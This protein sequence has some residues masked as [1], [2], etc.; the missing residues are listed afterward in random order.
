MRWANGAA[1]RTAVRD[2]LMVVM[3]LLLCASCAHGGDDV[4]ASAAAAS[5]SS[6]SSSAAAAASSPAR[7]SVF[8]LEH[9]VGGKFSQRGKYVIKW[10]AEGD[11]T[12][13]PLDA[14]KNVIG[15][16]DLPSF[17]TM[18]SDNALYRIRVLTRSADG[19][20]SKS[21]SA[22]LPAC[23]LQKSGFKEHLV[24]HL[25][26]RDQVI[27][28]GYTSPEMTISRPCDPSTVS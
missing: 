14:S 11:A 9:H 28:L 23:E 20:T 1:W 22:S 24:L 18:L 17:K 3:V 4:A 27:G 10:S 5:S 21:A 13:A 8:E 26:H 19:S 25:D 6:S 15:A 7:E 12:V 2:V 16:E